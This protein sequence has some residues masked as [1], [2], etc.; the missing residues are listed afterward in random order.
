LSFAGWGFA[1]WGFAAWAFGGAA[2]FGCVF[3]GGV[4]VALVFAGPTLDDW[5]FGAGRLAGV[6]ALAL[7]FDLAITA[8]SAAAFEAAGLALTE[9]LTTGLTEARGFV[10]AFMGSFGAALPLD[11]WEAWSEPFPGAV[12]L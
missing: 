12:L 11:F 9:G 4:R 6:S 7:T 3:G 2:R 5:A 1:G 10:A 8:F